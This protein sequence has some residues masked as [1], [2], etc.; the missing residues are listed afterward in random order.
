MIGRG[1]LIVLATTILH[2]TFWAATDT[3]Q[4]PGGWAPDAIREGTRPAFSYDANGGPEGKGA[5]VIEADGRAGLDG[6]WVKT[7][8]VE[9][10]LHYKFFALRKLTNVESPRRSA[11]ARIFWFNAAGQKVRH[12]FKGAKSYAGNMPPVAEA[13]YP[14]ARETNDAGWTEVSD[15]YLAPPDATQAVVELHFR[16][17]ANARC[18]WA[19]VAFAKS[20]P[21]E[22][23]LV[24]LATIHHRPQ[25]GTTAMENCEQFAPLIAEAAARKADLVVLPETLTCMGNGKTYFDV[26]ESI[27]GPSTD[28]FG[29]LAKKHGLY[30]VVGLV[31]RVDHLIYNV[32]VLIDRQGQV[33]GKYRKVTLPR[34][35]IDMGIMP[36]TEYPVFETDFG[37]VGMM[38]CYDGFF[39]EVARQ[40]SN[41]G[42]EV[43][44]FPVAGCNP[45]LAAARACENHVY[46]VSSSYSDVSSDWMITG[47]FDREGD[48]IAQAKEWGTVAV[49][50]VD[51]N[52]HLYWTSLGD[53]GAEIP[54]NRP[55]L[56]K[57]N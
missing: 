13:D 38:I 6:R 41:N 35:E 57:G 11:L 10:G 24:R 19:Q 26:G 17:A 40:L 55:L 52:Q 36:G 2:G 20:G 44:A 18:E 1:V 5:L 39:P 30:L 12:S 32:S 51:L 29:T 53:F 8:P 23:R 28:Y 9:G 48:V 4:A 47:V 46:V 3:P 34:T 7:F 54:H 14:Q 31:E 21:P 50:E 27:P 25:G 43:I 33:V 49:T 16:W 42:A 22:K 37:T 45:M 15:I 56:P